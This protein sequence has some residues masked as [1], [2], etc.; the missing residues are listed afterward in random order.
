MDS[1]KVESSGF[2][3]DFSH[4]VCDS[5]NSCSKVSNGGLDGASYGIN[6]SHRPI[7]QGLVMCWKASH[8]NPFTSASNRN[9]IPTTINWA[10]YNHDLVMDGLPNQTGNGIFQS[11]LGI[12]AGR[13]YFLSFKISVSNCAFSPFFPYLGFNSN[14]IPANADSFIVRF[15][16]GLSQASNPGPTAVP[17]ISQSQLIGQ[18]TDVQATPDPEWVEVRFCVKADA[19]YTSLWFYPIQT[20]GSEATRVRIKNVHLY[21][22]GAGTP[23]SVSVPCNS[24]TQLGF[25]CPNIP[26]ATYTWSPTTGLSNPNVLR[27]TLN[28]AAL[29]GQGPHAFN[30]TVNWNGCTLADTVN[31]QVTGIPTL[32]IPQ[33]NNVEVC[34][35]DFPVILDAQPVSTGVP[36][37]FQWY[38]Y[39]GSAGGMQPI[40]GATGSLLEVHGPG[41]YCVEARTRQGCFIQACFIV[42]H[43][44]PLT[45]NPDFGMT[46]WAPA[47]NPNYIIYVHPVNT[48]WNNIGQGY[49]ISEVDANGNFIQAVGISWGANAGQWLMTG[50]NWVLFERGRYYEIKHGIWNSCEWIE[51][52][53][54]V[55]ID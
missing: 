43:T 4:I 12:V 28:T 2:W 11:G 25:G 9:N 26:G 55:Y 53:R 20:S 7:G 14:H 13:L 15:A 32:G 45:L 10:Q 24:I 44:P 51:K 36:T 17:S 50:S 38:A 22:A 37:A 16:N 21:E 5:S 34:P 23:N 6:T 19:N 31:V 29:A 39:D 54:Y 35:G 40:P 8:G 27:P 46:T 33:W 30:L 42:Q 47:G 1:D 48:Q 52:R 3:P 49:Y 18:L 41:W